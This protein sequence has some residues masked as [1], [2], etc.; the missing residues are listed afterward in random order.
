VLIDTSLP[1]ALERIAERPRGGN[2][3]NSP[4]TNQ[5]IWERFAEAHKDRETDLR[6]DTEMV[7][8]AEAA[9]M[10]DGAVRQSSAESSAG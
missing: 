2:L 3:S 8:A 6:I 10:I 1:V 7:S 5:W 4:G 9:R